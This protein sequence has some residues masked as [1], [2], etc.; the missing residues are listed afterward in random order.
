TRGATS[1]TRRDL[2]SPLVAR[3]PRNQAYPCPYRAQRF[4]PTPW[5]AMPPRRFATPNPLATRKMVGVVTPK[6]H[7][8]ARSVRRRSEAQLAC[9]VREARR[10]SESSG[11]ARSGG[12]GVGR[13][14]WQDED[15]RR[16]LVEHATHADRA[17]D[18]LDNGMGQ[19]QPQPAAR[20]RA[21]PRVIAA[22]KPRE[23]ALLIR[24]AHP[25]A[26]IRDPELHGPLVIALTRPDRDR[27]PRRGVLDR[28]AH[29][30]GRGLAEQQVWHEGTQP[31]R[32]DI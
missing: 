1:R 31:R 15:K 13:G 32:A 19:C 10:G 3:A 18:S 7:P 26:S 14:G 6:C 20:L 8:E 11:P 17:A 5:H 9:R 25:N 27:A 22:E 29:E 30:V 23:H 12:R 24:L 2:D 28:V 4:P 21:C 16:P